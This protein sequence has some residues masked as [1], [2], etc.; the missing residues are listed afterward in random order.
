MPNASEM[1]FAASVAEPPEPDPFDWD[2]LSANDEELVPDRTSGTVAHHE[3]NLSSWRCMDCEHDSFVWS[4]NG[5]K[6]SRCDSSN[7]YQVTS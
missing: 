5:W 2:G 3:S 4:S 7:Y 6:C 1:P